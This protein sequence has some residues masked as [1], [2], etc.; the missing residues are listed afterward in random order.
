MKNALDMKKKHPYQVA[1]YDLVAQEDLGRPLKDLAPELIW[2][3][4]QRVSQGVE[5]PYFFHAGETLGDGT[6][7][8]DNLFD[9]VLFQSRRIGHGFSL[10]KHPELMNEYREKNIL[11]EVCPISS[12]VLRLATD[13]LHHPLPAMIAHGVPTAISNDDPNIQGQDAAGLSFDFYQTIQGFDNIG[14][15]GMGALAQNSVRW[16]NFEDQS[17]DAWIN[18]IKVGEKGTGL[19]AQRIQEWNTQWEEFC[20]WIVQEFGSWVDEQV[21]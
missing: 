15:A 4:E 9:A 5:I 17:Y 10:Y 13:I 7:T 8:D 1:G 6:T 2:F 18:D 11:V 20:S 19:K 14:L 21:R 12:E 3:N 16:S